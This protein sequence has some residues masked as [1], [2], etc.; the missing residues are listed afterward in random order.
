MHFIWSALFFILLL[1]INIIFDIEDELIDDEILE[2]LRKKQFTEI[3]TY[4]N[5]QI[6]PEKIIDILLNEGIDI[7]LDT[8]PLSKL[9]FE[10]AL[11]IWWIC[12]Q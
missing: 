1:Q 4:H 8:I 11:S 10:R 6:K 7:G 5:E 2:L 9:S 12:K 3:V